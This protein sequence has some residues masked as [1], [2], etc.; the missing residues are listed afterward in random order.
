MA[1]ETALA[2]VMPIWAAV[3]GAAT[4]CVVLKASMNKPVTAD[5]PRLPM[6]RPIY[7]SFILAAGTSHHHRKCGVPWRSVLAVVSPGAGVCSLARS[8]LMIVVYAKFNVIQPNFGESSRPS[9]RCMEPFDLTT[10][11]TSSPLDPGSSRGEN[12]LSKLRQACQT[13]VQTGALAWPTG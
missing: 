8:R 7:V 5:T 1:F 11:S 2:G 13:A 4:A 3:E 12:A 6:I 10:E 9:D